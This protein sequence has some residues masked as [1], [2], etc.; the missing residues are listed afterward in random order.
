MLA[1][2]DEVSSARVRELYEA[3]VALSNDAPRREIYETRFF[4]GF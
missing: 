4:L 3:R 2:A 1:S